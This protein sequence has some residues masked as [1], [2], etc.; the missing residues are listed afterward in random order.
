MS[1]FFTEFY[2][3]SWKGDLERYKRYASMAARSDCPHIQAI[4]EKSRNYIRGQYPTHATVFND[5]DTECKAV[6][7]FN[8]TPKEV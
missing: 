7:N 5:I 1:D 6:Y 4:A 8:I 3:R 2:Q